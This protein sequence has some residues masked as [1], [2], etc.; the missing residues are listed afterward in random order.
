M[1]NSFNALALALTLVAV[2]AGVGCATTAARDQAPAAQM[3]FVWLKSG[4]TSGQGAKPQRD[5]MFKGHMANINRLAHEKKLVIAGPYA[6]P[7]DKDWRG[8]LVLDVPTVA[9]AQALAATDPGVIAGE[10]VAVC[11]RVTGSPTLRQALDLD[12]ELQAARKANP[13]NPPPNIRP[14]VLVTTTD[15]ARC[16]KALAQ[17]DSAPSIVW[18]LR[19]VDIPG[20]VLALDA[21]AAAPIAEGLA[22]I[23]PDAGGVDGWFSTAALTKL[24]AEASK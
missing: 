20:G 14:Y 10:F 3:V 9:E 15:L 1:P 12:G 2:A 11:E 7:R 8:V 22:K 17:L 19:F 23:D 5:E 4:P 16:R 24:P 21:Q 13:Q 6:K 18:C